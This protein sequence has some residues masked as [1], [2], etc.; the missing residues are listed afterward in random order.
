MPAFLEHTRRVQLI[1]NGEIVVL[2]PEGVSIT[3]A[4]GE[5][6]EREVESVD[7]DAE[8]AEKG[9]YETFML[10]EIFEQ[11]DADRRRHLR[12]H[13]PRPTTSSW[14]RRARWTSRCCATSR[15]S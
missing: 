8:T 13:R 3:T 12:T 1:E 9:G 14:P 2:T 5:P 11:A 7:W 10:K 4:A 15:G 6:V